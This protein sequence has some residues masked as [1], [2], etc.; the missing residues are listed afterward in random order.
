MERKGDWCQ[1]YLGKKFYPLDP[2]PEDFYIED[3]A[4]A[5]SN[6]CRFGGH[7]SE[8]YTVAQH[9]VIISDLC[10]PQNAL[11]G[12][13]HDGMEAYLVDIPRPVKRCLPD[14]IECE[15]LVMENMA[16]AFNLPMPMPKEVKNLDTYLLTVERDLLMKTELDWGLVYDD[17]KLDIKIEKFW[18]PEEAK[19]EFLNRY[20]SLKAKRWIREG[21]L[22]C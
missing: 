10:S 5:L 8:F 9:S 1:T 11:W 17:L 3:I 15:Q 4:H 20:I 16:K 21:D 6:L 12:L 18:S 22:K 2:R 7:S 19:T 13:L 14:Y